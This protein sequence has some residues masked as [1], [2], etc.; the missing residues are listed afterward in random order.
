[1]KSHYA[2]FIFLLLGMVKGFSQV[3][4]PGSLDDKNTPLVKSKGEIGEKDFVNFA[5]KSSLKFEPSL[6]TR[7]VFAFGYEHQLVHNLTLQGTAG[8]AIDKDFVQVNNVIP[9]QSDNV[10]EN[11]IPMEDILKNGRGGKTGYYISGDT[12][13]YFSNDIF[14]DGYFGFKLSHNMY[15]LT[16]RAGTTFYNYTPASTSYYVPNDINTR[17]FNTSFSIIG[18]VQLATKGTIKTTHDI[19]FGVGLNLISYKRFTKEKVPN[20]INVNEGPKSLGKT[21][22]IS[23]GYAIG[24][25]M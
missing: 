10:P 19:Y 14:N 3:D 7:G 11:E 12:K 17:I 20:R 24:I 16:Y 2:L 22:Y 5:I 21:I 15:G 23:F 25:G 8:I 18:G 1:M 4:Y 9:I 13:I 6:L